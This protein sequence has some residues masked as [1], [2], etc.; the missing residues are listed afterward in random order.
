M[1]RWTDAE[2]VY[3]ESEYGKYS[4]KV[5]ASKLGRT[6]YAVNAKAWKMGLRMLDNQE[7]LTTADFCEHT[8]IHRSTME[9][10]IKECGFPTT[11]IFKYRRIYP[12]RFWKW[13]EENKHRIQWANFPDYGVGNEPKW[14]KTARQGNTFRTTKR[15]PWTQW[16]LNKLE[17]ML[18]QD[19]YT[20]PELSKELNR[21]HGAIKRKIYD[22]NLPWPVYLDRNPTS[23]EPYTDEELEKA[24]N[25]YQEGYPLAEVARELNRSEGGLRAKLERS[26][27]RFEG[28]V[29]MEV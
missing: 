26:G 25:M 18:E 22:L 8:G 13:A 19:K 27:Y 23:A 9:Y 10:W 1:K 16:E 20:Y 28:K 7:W 15:R 24:I 6:E 17:L 21:S 4:A 5:L 12:K 2:A 14:V 11:K 29:L 3:L